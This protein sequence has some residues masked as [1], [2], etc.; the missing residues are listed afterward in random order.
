MKGK[1]EQIT[2][3]TLWTMNLNREEVIRKCRDLTG[4]QEMPYEP[5]F[6][7]SFLLAVYKGYYFSHLKGSKVQ[8]NRKG[9]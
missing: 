6:W 4:C 2:K 3:T 8:I 9:G 1:R 5:N 7:L